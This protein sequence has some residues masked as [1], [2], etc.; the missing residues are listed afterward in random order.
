MVGSRRAAERRPGRVAPGRASSSQVEGLRVKDDRGH[1]RGAR[2]QLRGARRRDL[3]ASPA[4]RATARTSWSRP[5]SGCAT[6]P[7]GTD[8][9]R[10]PGHHAATAPRAPRAGHRV[11]A[12]RPPPLRARAARSRSPTTSCLTQLL[13]SRRTRAGIVPQRRGDPRAG[14]ARR[15][16]SSTSATPSVDVTAG[17]LS[18]GNQQKVVVAREFGRDLKLLVLDQPTRGLDVG[19]IEFIHRQID[20]QA[21]RRAPRSCW[22]RPSS[23]RCW[24]SP[25]GSRVMYRGQLVAMLD[26]PSA[27]NG[28][29]RTPHGDRRPGERTAACRLTVRS[30]RAADGLGRRSR[31]TP[32]A[33][34]SRRGS[35]AVA[36]RVPIASILLARRGVGA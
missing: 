15:S 22:S 18:G 16:R 10:R 13:R 31:L 3:R 24:S 34:R 23:T 33:P 17:T 2:R 20:R 35:L 6:P 29:G 30:P 21:R 5:S 14:R 36:D 7:A 27:P 19:S 12:G 1:E 11:R 4:W 28:G 32:A 8:P 9:T 26:G 25:T